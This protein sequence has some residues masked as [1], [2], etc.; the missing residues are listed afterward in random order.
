MNLENHIDSAL[1]QVGPQIGMLEGIMTTRAM[2]R[3]TTEPIPDDVLWKIMQ[4][5]NQAPSGG[6]IQ[7]WQFLVITEPDVKAPLGEL[8]RRCYERYERA[9]LPTRSGPST[10]EAD[11][12][13][14][15][16][17]DA[18]R[19]MAA[20][21]HE[22]PAIVIVLGADID[23]TIT[24]DIGPLDIGSILGS[25]FPAVQNLMLAARSF[26]LGSA[27]TTVL[28]IEHD[29]TRTLLAI[30]SRWN[31]IGAIPMG[32]PTGRFGVAPRKPVAKV[33]HW[34]RFGEKREPPA[35]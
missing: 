16:T 5:A 35:G 14:Q 12:A 27:L 17:I 3:L 18:S 21:F 25:I 32:Y 23:L 8:Y 34:N 31:V 33:T 29:E 6:N 1:T 9:M 4:A 22:A 19:H 30:P 11:A 24:D 7:P 15:R 2:R 10:P 28:R 26:G 20:H 13:W